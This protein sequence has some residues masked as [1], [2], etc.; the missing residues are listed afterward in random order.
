MEIGWLM[1]GGAILVAVALI[2]WD[3]RRMRRR[4]EREARSARPFPDLDKWKEWD[5]QI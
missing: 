4:A 2:I 3:N 1:V 5:R